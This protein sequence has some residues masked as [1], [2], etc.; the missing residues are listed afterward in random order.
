MKG[1]HKIYIFKGSLRLLTSSL[2]RSFER[3]IG[4]FLC[5]SVANFTI[6]LLLKNL[7]R[8]IIKRQTLILRLQSARNNPLL[9]ALLCFLLFFCL[10][11]HCLSRF[12]ILIFCHH[13][14]AIQKFLFCIYQIKLI[15]FGKNF[16]L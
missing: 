14:L 11:N 13:L 6:S 10:F 5:F 12:I 8:K 15:I 1:L 16:M 2:D 9:L 3:V 7:W 4:N